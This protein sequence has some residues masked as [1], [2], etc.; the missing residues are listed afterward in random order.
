MACIKF[1]PVAL[2][3]CS[4]QRVEQL[5]RDL[6]DAAADVAHQVHVLVLVDRVARRAV[7]Q[8]G[9]PHEP[10]PVEQVERAVDRGDVDRRRRLL[11]ALSDLF[12]RRVLQRP[13]R[14]Q[15]EL[16]LRRH[17]QTPPVQGLPELGVHLPDGRPDGAVGPRASRRP[18]TVPTIGGP[19]HEGRH[20]EV[21]HDHG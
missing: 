3:Q 18:R 20:G 14:V 19:A 17:A 2:P 5:T 12:G 1:E 13:D 11:D 7:A 10:E 21:I 16:A 4:D 9:V 8:V 15:H 6:L